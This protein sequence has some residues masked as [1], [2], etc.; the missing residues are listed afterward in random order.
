V[1]YLRVST[2]EQADSGLGLGAQRAVIEAEAARRG[3][4]LVT[5]LVDAG[6]S[7][8]SLSGR[9]ALAEALGLVRSGA[10]DV[11]VVAKLD[12]LSRSL[13]DF[14]GLMADAQGRGW[15]LVAL[16][17]GIDLS[18]PAG[19]FMASVM[20]SAAQWERR[21]VGQRTREAL[22]VK[23]A[24]GVRLG[25]PAVLAQDVVNRIV[26]DRATGMTLTAIADAL[27]AQQVPTARGGARWYASTV[28]AV[29]GSQAARRSSS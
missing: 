3:W 7:G 2:E 4:E 24:Q 17:L 25:R 16:D 23:R 12:R 18:T 10:A 26:T 28:S 6:A 14:A 20:A 13:L 19:E 21:L 11:L 27:N 8:K 5:V 29:L 15:V 1:G 9:P 22:A